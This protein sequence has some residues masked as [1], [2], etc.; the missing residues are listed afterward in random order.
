MI[1]CKVYKLHFPGEL[2]TV[3]SQGVDGMGMGMQTYFADI[4]LP[5]R[6]HVCNAKLDKLLRLEPTK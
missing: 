5:W 6:V 4:A 3:R 2:V 1:F